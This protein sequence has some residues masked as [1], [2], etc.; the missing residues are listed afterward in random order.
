MI[1]PRSFYEPISALLRR[2]T[3]EG[4]AVQPTLWTTVINHGE[5]FYVLVYKK[6]FNASKSYLLIVLDKFSP[7][8]PFLN[9]GYAIG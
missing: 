1:E 2:P 8:W 5:V 9:I 7:Y 3:E 6:G 4:G